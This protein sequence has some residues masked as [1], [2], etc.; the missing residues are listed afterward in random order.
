MLPEAVM[1]QAQEEFINWQSHG[2]S[3]ME[4]SHRSEAYIEVA[5]NLWHLA[6]PDLPPR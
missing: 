1:R 5:V 2:S 3:V 4:L 6:Q